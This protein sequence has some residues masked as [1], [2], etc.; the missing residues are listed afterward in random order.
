MHAIPQYPETIQVVQT[1]K[2]GGVHIYL[3]LAATSADERVKRPSRPISAMKPSIT[4]MPTTGLEPPLGG[5]RVAPSLQL[6]RS[7]LGEAVA[8]CPYLVL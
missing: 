8:G 1:N 4:K 3:A 5:Q 7:R 2:C 6:N